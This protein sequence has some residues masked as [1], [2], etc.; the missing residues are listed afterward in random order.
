M[1]WIN[2]TELEGII[3]ENLK[4]AIG[5]KAAES[6]EQA[7]GK[8]KKDFRTRYRA[9]TS[10]DYELLAISTPGMRVARAK[11]IPGY[12]PDY[13]CITAPGAVTVV[14][15]P[16][17]REGTV[18]PVPGNGFIQ[19]VFRHLDIHRLVT[20]DL[21]VIGPQYVK[22]SVKC[23]I[24]M[25]KRSSPAEVSKRVMEAL[26]RFLDPLADGPDGEGWPFGRSVFPSEIYQI[27]DGVEGVDYATGV[28]LSAEGQHQ[29]VGDIIRI[30]QISLVFSG[31]HQV[32]II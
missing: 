26:E 22:I 27:I 5:G 12:N 29:K 32:E 2:K 3:G 1:W 30:P 8:A 18:T 10:G 23:K 13:P 24:R 15:V 31:E 28:S 21:Y 6:I 4:K 14:V 19:T 7:K 16:Y 11:A 20:T 25:V 17:A 9:I